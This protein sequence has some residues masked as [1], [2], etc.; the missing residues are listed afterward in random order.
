MFKKTRKCL[1]RMVPKFLAACEY[2]LFVRLSHR[3]VIHY[4][5]IYK[6]A[7]HFFWVYLGI[8]TLFII[9]KHQVKVL[10]RNC[11][12]NMQVTILFYATYRMA[13][14]FCMQRT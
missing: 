5:I 11:E 6:F 3:I 14:Y 10:K 7:G 2:F 12:A 13:E 8:Y 9:T 1:D 4:V